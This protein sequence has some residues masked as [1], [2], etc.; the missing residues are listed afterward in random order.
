MLGDGYRALVDVKVAVALV[1]VVEVS[2][3]VVEVVA[4]VVSFLRDG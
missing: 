4:A 3:V 2:V 1:S